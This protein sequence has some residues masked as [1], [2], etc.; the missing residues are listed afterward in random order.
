MYTVDLGGPR[1]LINA[2]AEHPTD[3]VMNPIILKVHAGPSLS[4]SAA[5]A[6]LVIVPPRPPPAY[7]IPFARPLR[8]LKY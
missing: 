1:S 2:A 8:F 6:K 3:R 5:I 4:R 7:T